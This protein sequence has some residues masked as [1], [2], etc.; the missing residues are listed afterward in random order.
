MNV[1]IDTNAFYNNW[2]VGNAH[3]K[4]LFHYLNNEQLDLLLSD[5][6]VQEV[7]NL[8]NKEVSES[9]VEIK[10]L[11]S[12]LKKLNRGGVGVSVDE[13]TISE[14]DI[15][16]ILHAK[17]H[18]VEGIS[19]ENIP[20]TDVVNR[21]LKVVKPFTDGEKG[22]RDT[23][24]WLSFLKYLQD[25]QVTEPVA[26]I[27]DNKSDF[28]DKKGTEL[29]FNQDLLNDINALGMQ[30]EIKP[31]LNVFD[32]VKDNVDQ[33]SHAVDRQEILDDQE[34]FLTHETESYLD[35]MS[36]SSLSELL[37]TRVFSDKLTEVVD[38]KSTIFEGLEDPEVDY[39]SELASPSVYI[40]CKYEMR[41]VD[42]VVTIELVEFKQHADDLEAI[43]SL[44]N[45]Q[46]DGDYVNLSFMFRCLDITAAFE[47]NTALEECSNLTVENIW[48]QS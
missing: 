44:Y 9:K 22:Y 7:N 20:H 32:F 31:Y 10:R 35:A 29:V 8:R 25:N 13:M 28:F 45:I 39:V 19:Y 36:N 46:I 11:L 16:E 3:F 5:L 1:F 43:D 15:Q 6:V 18:S 33:V 48:V 21:A 27:T 12:R 30:T 4:L 47:Y 2:F 38:I 23:L 24:I 41:H 37:S 42:L 26:F 34:H 17:V 40:N 14:Y